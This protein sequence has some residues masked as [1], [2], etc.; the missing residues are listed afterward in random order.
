MSAEATETSNIQGDVNDKSSGDAA[1]I[2]TPTPT[3]QEPTTPNSVAT[4]N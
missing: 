1:A 4:L 3:V 2:A